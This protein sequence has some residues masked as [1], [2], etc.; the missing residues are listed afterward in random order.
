MNVG[1]YACKQTNREQE[2]D[3]ADSLSV[4]SLM[5]IISHPPFQVHKQLPIIK[6]CCDSLWAAVWSSFQPSVSCMCCAEKLRVAEFPAS[7]AKHLSIHLTLPNELLGFVSFIIW[8]LGL[9]S[10]QCW[11]RILPK[12]CFTISLLQTVIPR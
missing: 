12:L 2:A 3:R 11:A 5:K 4:N 9:T 1:V 8:W 7:S 10:A 6:D